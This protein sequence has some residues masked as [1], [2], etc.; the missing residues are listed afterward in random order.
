MLGERHWQSRAALALEERRAAWRVDEVSCWRVEEV[1]RIL[2]RSGRFRRRQV[3]CSGI[4]EGE[5]SCLASGISEGEQCWQR[6]AVLAEA[7]GVGAGGEASCMVSGGGELLA[8]GGGELRVERSLWRIVREAE[9]ERER[10]ER[11]GLREK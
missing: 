10:E 9:I 6:Q 7:S 1:N 8:S 5:A 2:V 11:E 4:G 3:D